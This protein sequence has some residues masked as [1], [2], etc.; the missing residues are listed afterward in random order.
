MGVSDLGVSLG[1]CVGG[2]VKSLGYQNPTKNSTNQTCRAGSRS[3][4]IASVDGVPGS[5]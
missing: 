5:D 4:E 1:S 2:R 3:R